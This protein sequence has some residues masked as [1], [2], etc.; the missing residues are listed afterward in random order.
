MA[1]KAAADGCP[2]LSEGSTGPCVLAYET[3]LASLHPRGALAV[4][5]R[6]T[7]T[8]RTLTVQFEREVLFRL[9]PTGEA[10]AEVQAAVQSLPAATPRNEIILGASNTVGLKSVGLKRALVYQGA[11]NVR[12]DA[13]GGT[14]T[15]KGENNALKRLKARERTIKYDRIQIYTGINDLGWAKRDLRLPGYLD[16][17]RKF[18]DYVDGRPVLWGTVAKSKSGSWGI[19]NEALRLAQAEYPNLTLLD[20]ATPMAAHPEWYTKDGVHLTK[21]GYTARLGCVATAVNREW[22]GVLGCP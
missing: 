19:W 18:M 8:T 5:G 4:D 16:M 3:A 2:T 15:T 1:G 14:S 9:H 10:D 20:L 21:A 22:A 7:G 12:I 6:Y 17:I 13:I 11:S